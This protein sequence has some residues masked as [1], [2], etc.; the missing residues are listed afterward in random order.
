MRYWIQLATEQFPPSALLEGRCRTGVTLDFREAFIVASDPGVHV[1]HVREVERLGAT[2]V[3]LQ[4]GSGAAP[5]TR[6]VCRAKHV[7][8]D[9]RA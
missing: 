8:P 2:V 1:E 5:S 6:C 4:N 7:L 9:L 3:C